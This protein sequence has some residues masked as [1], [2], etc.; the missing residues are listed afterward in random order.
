MPR[1]KGGLFLP[2]DVNFMDDPRVV[3]AGRDAAWLY[4][5]MALACKRLNTDGR[6]EPLQVDRLHVPSWKKLMPTLLHEELVLDLDDGSYTIAAWFRHNDPAAVVAERR[7]ADSARK[8]GTGSE[9]NPNGIRTESVPSRDVEKNRVEKREV[10][11]PPHGPC[12]GCSEC[13]TS[14]SLKVVGS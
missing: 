11:I 12:P 1:R 4:L 10:R 5:A 14:A 7:A 6:L 9:R 2:L 3:R 13:P 8:R